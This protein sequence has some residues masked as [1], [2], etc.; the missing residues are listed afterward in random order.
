[1]DPSNAFGSHEINVQSQVFDTLAT[2]D[3]QLNQLPWLATSWTLQTP[4]TWQGKLRTGVK[5]SNG[6]SLGADYVM[7]KFKYI[8]RA[9]CQAAPNF[10]CWATVEKVADRPVKV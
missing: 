5:F 6:A 10:Q 7:A 3:P 1:M 8:T 9:D 4:T 2:I